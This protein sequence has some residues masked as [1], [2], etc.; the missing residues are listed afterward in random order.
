MTNILISTGG[1]IACTSINGALEP[2]KSAADLAAL[3]DA[4]VEAVDFRQLDSSAMTL[5]DV[6]ELVECV[7]DYASRPEV[8]RVV[9]THGTDSME[10]TAVALALF[11]AGRTPVILTG[12]QRPFDAPAPDGPGNLRGALSVAPGTGGVFIH[13]GG[14]TVPAWGAT[15]QHTQSLNAF[16]APETTAPNCLPL[17][18]AR[19]AEEKVTI[20][21]A[22]PGAPGDMVDAAVAAGYAG[23]VVAA[24]GSGNVG[25]QMAAALDRALDAGVKVVISTRVAAGPVELIYGGAGGGNTLADKGAIN[26]GRLRPGQA[27]IVLAAALATQTDPAKL[28]A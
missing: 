6:D 23:I 22:Y 5:H 2:T 3:V 25:P 24:M 19:L 28:F 18:R 26:A 12:A 11:H 10:E 16:T 27:R 13:F 7:E 1:T 9:V 14:A 21:Y 20:I 17:P 8:T 4:P 15:K